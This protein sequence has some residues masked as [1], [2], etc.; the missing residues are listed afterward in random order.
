MD[1]FKFLFR[2]YNFIHSI[3]GLRNEISNNFAGISSH[4]RNLTNNLDKPQSPRRTHGGDAPTTLNQPAAHHPGHSTTLALNLTLVKSKGY[5]LVP[6]RNWDLTGV[7]KAIKGS[8]VYALKVLYGTKRD[9]ESDRP[10]GELAILQ[11]LQTL[12]P[13]RH[14]VIELVDVIPSKDDIVI[15]AMPWESPLDIFLAA[16]PNTTHSLG[17]QF[18]EGVAFLHKHHFAHLDLKPENLVICSTDVSL[19]PRLS[20]IDFGTSV[21]V[22]SELSEV[23][24]YRGTPSW[25]A[26]EVGTEFGDMRKYR[27]IM[28][29][30]WSCGRVLEHITHFH[31][32]NHSKFDRI[33][34]YLLS[35]DPMQRP[36]LGKVLQDIQERV[37]FV[38]SGGRA[39]ESRETTIPLTAPGNRSF[40]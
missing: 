19:L 40:S 38:M 4:L 3:D 21:R 17:V 24:G 28:A 2:L 33:C 37:Q 13:S 16:C 26:P 1:L 27:P 31:P 8:H 7:M 15:I 32:V 18:I 20:I 6:D 5:Q 12:Q 10:T 34:Q 36:S 35:E 11:Y 9:P 14:H 25:V 22:D 23:C 29:D 39:N 30:R